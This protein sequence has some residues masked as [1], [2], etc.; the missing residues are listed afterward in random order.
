M[1]TRY[2]KWA[3]QTEESLREALDALLS[4]E[5]PLDDVFSAIELAELAYR[6]ANGE[7]PEDD[8]PEDVQFECI[9][10]PELV[11]RGGFKG[12]CPVHAPV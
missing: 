7:R 2:A 3:A 1:I 10:P 12:G 6:I 11:A 5:R 9:C 4:D 8:W